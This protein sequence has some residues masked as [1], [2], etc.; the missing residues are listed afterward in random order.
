MQMELLNGE[1]CASLPSSA[2]F[3]PHPPRMWVIHDLHP[4]KV[5][6]SNLNFF[7]S[8]RCEMY[9]IMILVL[10]WIFLNIEKTGY[11]LIYSLTTW[12]INSLFIS[13]AH[14]SIELFVF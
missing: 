11:L 9:H 5:I 13:F 12:P 7:H 8:D 2:R 14:F 1:V 10:N 3:Y 4:H 6:Q